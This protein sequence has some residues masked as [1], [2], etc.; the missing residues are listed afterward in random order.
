MKILNKTFGEYATNCYILSGISG[1]L[2]IDPGVNSS[3][4]VLKNTTKILAVL[5]THGHFDHTFNDK[6]L[7]SKGAKIYIHEADAFMIKNDPFGYLKDAC[8]ADFCVKSGE[9]LKFGDFEVKFWHL[10]GHSPGSC[11]IFVRE[12]LSKN[13]QN[14]E[15]LSCENL[16]DKNSQNFKGSKNFKNSKNNEIF[17]AI[18]SGDVL[19]R[20]SIGRSDFPFSNEKDM[21]NSL[22]EIL[23]FSENS[24]KD[25]KIFP[26]HGESSSILTE[27]KSINYFLR[28][29]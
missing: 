9:I 10:P 25:Y 28:Y 15:N 7:Q 2:I 27:V 26:G 18:F 14:G 17:E 1:D 22:Q 21:K 5:N 29:M 16:G 11:M 24:Q 6:I 13:S 19:F 8:K 4:W 12:I 23:K 20:G 3:E